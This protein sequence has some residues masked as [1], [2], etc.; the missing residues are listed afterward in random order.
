MW[1][2]HLQHIDAAKVKCN[3]QAQHRLRAAGLISLGDILLP[4]GHFKDWETLDLN[5]HD[6]AGRRAYQAIIGAFLNLKLYV[7]HTRS[8]LVRIHTEITGGCGNS[9]STRCLFQLATHQRVQPPGTHLQGYCWT[10]SR[11][12][13][14]QCAKCS[15]TPSS[16]LTLPSRPQ[17]STLSLW[18]LVH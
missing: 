17:I 18:R 4:D 10:D 7:V 14:K 3:T 2:P 9:T 1:R 15:S 6:V 11:H 12:T 5:I 8:S 16:D 13:E